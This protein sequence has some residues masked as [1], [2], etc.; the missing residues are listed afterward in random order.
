MYEQVHEFT[1]DDKD[2]FVSDAIFLLSAW[3]DDHR[4]VDGIPSF[5]RNKCTLNEVSRSNS[6]DKYM[7]SQTGDNSGDNIQQN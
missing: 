6:A 5:A 1:L 3:L 4:S 7:S 2:N